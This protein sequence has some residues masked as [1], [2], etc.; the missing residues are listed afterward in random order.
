MRGR[1]IHTIRLIS[2]RQRQ[3]PIER[4]TY[5]AVH[6]VVLQRQV[7]ARSQPIQIMSIHIPL[8]KFI[9]AQTFV[10]YARYEKRESTTDFYKIL[11][12]KNPR[13]EQ[14]QDT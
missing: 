14:E 12:I 4:D 6:S 9:L 3:I 13:A 2:T 5:W 7:L 8:F 1:K 11:G 10:V